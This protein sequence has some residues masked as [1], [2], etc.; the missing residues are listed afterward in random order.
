M[1]KMAKGP[2][3]PHIPIREAICHGVLWG[4]SLKLRLKAGHRPYINQC[5]SSQVHETFPRFTVHKKK[6]KN[7]RFWGALDS[8]SPQ[9][10][11]STGST[12]T[13]R[14]RLDLPR[15][16][17]DPLGKQVEDEID[18]AELTLYVQYEMYAMCDVSACFYSIPTTTCIH[19]HYIITYDG[20]YSNDYIHIHIYIYIYTRTIYHDQWRQN[21]FTPLPIG[22]A[23]DAN[24]SSFCAQCLY[25]WILEVWWIRDWFQILCIASCWF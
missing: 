13:L 11:D 20:K 23:G 22:I 7:N 19:C 14:R 5:R 16:L 1:I 3:W 10:C 21:Q 4:Y 6:W 8:H 2:K 15:C 12:F 24:I 25:L 9:F 18:L 17:N